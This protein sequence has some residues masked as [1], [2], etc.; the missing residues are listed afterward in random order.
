MTIYCKKTQELNSIL[1]DFSLVKVSYWMEGIFMYRH[2]SYAL[3]S[4]NQLI[5][6][7]LKS[8]FHQ[9]KN[10]NHVRNKIIL[11]DTPYPT[12]LHMHSLKNLQ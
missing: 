8:L 2:G 11:G 3:N 1:Y 7:M 4:W 10:K 6:K 5:G 12:T 9:E